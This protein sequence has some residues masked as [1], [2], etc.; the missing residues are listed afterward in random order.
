MTWKAKSMLAA[1]S[2]IK[3]PFLLMLVVHTFGNPFG[4]GFYIATGIILDS[5][6]TIFYLLILPIRLFVP[7]LPLG[8]MQ[9]TI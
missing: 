3:C 4:Q 6:I 9:P 5:L 1:P 7:G 2:Y 8:F